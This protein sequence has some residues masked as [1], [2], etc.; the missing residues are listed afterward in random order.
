MK[1]NATF[2]TQSNH[3]DVYYQPKYRKF[4][5]SEKVNEWLRI[6]ERGNKKILTYKNWHNDMYCDEYEVEIDD[7]ENLDRIFNILGLEKIAAVDKVRTT[8]RYLN[9]YKV[10]LDNIKEL[11][12]FIEMKIEEISNDITKE[13]E[14]LL[15]IAKSLNLN[16]N[17][18]EHRRYPYQIV[19]KNKKTSDYYN[20]GL[21]MNL[22]DYSIILDDNNCNKH[23]NWH[24][25]EIK[26]GIY[27]EF[28]KVEEEV[29]EAKEALE[30]NNHLM[31]LIELSDI[32]GAIE[33]IA[34][35]YGL[36]LKD[37]INFSNKVKESKKYE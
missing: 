17:H 18:I 35:N 23:F 12:Y 27:G 4:L 11:G 13:Y 6:G 36:T 1:N 9:K 14:E 32:I 22:K 20:G 33:K 26:K 28:S 31:Y 2:L 34:E 19:C 10:S 30:Q 24:N 5:N 21:L 16:L 15:K 37:L 29:D 3:H 25:R 7:S 8:F